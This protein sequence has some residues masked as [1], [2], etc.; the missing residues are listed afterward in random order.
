ME[1]LQLAVLH[2]QEPTRLIWWEFLCARDAE[3]CPGCNLVI[4][5]AADV[6]DLLADLVT[7]YLRGRILRR[8]QEPDP[9]RTRG[10]PEPL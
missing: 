6:P 3:N 5:A 2:I 1:L 10:E 4:H 9:W 8:E 7:E